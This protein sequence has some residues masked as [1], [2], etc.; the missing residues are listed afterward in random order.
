MQAPPWS[1]L[2]AHSLLIPCSLPAHSPHVLCCAPR[3]PRA[4]HPPCLHYALLQVAGLLHAAAAR[5]ELELDLDVPRG[6]TSRSRAFSA[7]E[8]RPYAPGREAHRLPRVDRLGGA[9]TEIEPDR[10]RPLTAPLRT[11]AITRAQ[12]RSSISSSISI[13][14]KAKAKAKAKAGAEAEAKA[15]GRAARAEAIA[16]CQTSSTV[17]VVVERRASAISAISAISAAEGGSH[18]EGEGE[19][20]AAYKA[21]LKAADAA[22]AATAVASAAVAATGSMMVWYSGVHLLAPARAAALEG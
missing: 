1:R 17:E 14:I 7:A 21:S 3:V 18:S 5:I 8:L 4:L 15:D 6:L 11:A 10:P 12:P 2:T 19:Y 9:A 16:L 20:Y 22:V 13:P